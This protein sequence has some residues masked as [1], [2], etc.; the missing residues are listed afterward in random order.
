MGARRFEE[1]LPSV[2]IKMT[3]EIACTLPDLRG[4]ISKIKLGSDP[5]EC[6][7]SL[8]AESLIPGL[9]PVLPTKAPHHGR[10]DRF[11]LTG[12]VPTL[13]ENRS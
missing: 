1:A 13:R 4:P 12:S 5:S 2:I 6:Q 11:V 7:H 3:T 10:L 8:F 9:Q